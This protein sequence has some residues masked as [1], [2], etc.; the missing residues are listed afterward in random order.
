MIRCMR[1]LHN[2]SFLSGHYGIES[3]WAH[4]RKAF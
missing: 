4:H 1:L 3:F 2:D